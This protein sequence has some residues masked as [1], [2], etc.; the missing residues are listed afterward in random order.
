MVV[1]DT[2]VTQLPAP[3]ETVTWRPAT[4]KVPDLAAPLLAATEM[5]MLPLPFPDAPL[6]IV[7]NASLL[8]AVQPQLVPDCDTDTITVDVP[9]AA[10]IE[11]GFGNT[12][13]VHVGATM[14]MRLVPVLF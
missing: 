12:E 11:T 1:G 10:P 6:V 7:M 2:E 3:C 5:V 13:N 8:T 4:V 9:P 14:L